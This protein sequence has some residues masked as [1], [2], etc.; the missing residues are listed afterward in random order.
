[1]EEELRLMQD[2]WPSETPEP[3]MQEEMQIP[4]KPWG[5][6]VELAISPRGFPYVPLQ[7]SGFRSGIQVPGEFP[8]FP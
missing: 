7:A 5:T 1:M 3:E 2:L 6:A 4:A 8:I